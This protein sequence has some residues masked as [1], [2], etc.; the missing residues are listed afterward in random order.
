[1]KL[2]YCNIT[3]GMVTTP[4]LAFAVM[5]FDFEERILPVPDQKKQNS[6]CGS[7]TER[8]TRRWLQL[9]PSK[10]LRLVDPKVPGSSPA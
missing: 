3:V 5:V 9:A 6:K 8:E 4:V 7:E 10:S 1:M 2:F